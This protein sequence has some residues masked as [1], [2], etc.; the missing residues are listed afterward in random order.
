MFIANGGSAAPL[1]VTD[2]S[3]YIQNLYADPVGNGFV[4]GTSYLVMRLNPDT[5]TPP[6]SGTQRYS[7][8]WQGNSATTPGGNPGNGPFITLTTVP[9]PG[10]ACLATLSLI[11]CL[12]VA[13][14]QD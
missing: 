11:G 7:V 13:R 14:R 8:A 10:G 4:P 6:S 3:S 12:L 9:E 5:S 2:V 1:D